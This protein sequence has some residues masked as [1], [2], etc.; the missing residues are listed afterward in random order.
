MC[1]L[2][3]AS[4]GF[5]V[6]ILQSLHDPPAGRAD[7]TMESRSSRRSRNPMDLNRMSLSILAWCRNGATNTAQKTQLFEPKWI[8]IL[9]SEP[10]SAM[11]CKTP[12]NSSWP[13]IA[14]RPPHPMGTFSASTLLNRSSYSQSPLPRTLLSLT[15]RLEP[16]LRIAIHI[17]VCGLTLC[18]LVPRT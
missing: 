16:Q 2:G 5:V 13:C 3:F 8:Y 11:L 7:D 14:H 1:P 18:L 4:L 10:T 15:Q 17:S 9:M 6:A 12:Q